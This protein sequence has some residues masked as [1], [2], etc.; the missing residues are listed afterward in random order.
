[1]VWHC[2]HSSLS[3]SKAGKW[4]H[5][6]LLLQ[7]GD[8]LIYTRS[9]AEPGEEGRQHSLLQLL[10]DRCFIHEQEQIFIRWA[11]Q[12]YGPNPRSNVKLPGW[13]HGC[14]IPDS[15]FFLEARSGRWKMEHT[16]PCLGLARKKKPTGVWGHDVQIRT[17]EH[18]QRLPPEHARAASMKFPEPT[19]G[20][21]CS[22]FPELGKIQ[23]SNSLKALLSKN[24]SQKWRKEYDKTFL[25][26][27]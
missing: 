9:P 12:S 10:Q 23:L 24:P 26:A 1:M 16:Y 5:L 14:W 17:Y 11:F 8:G 18:A 22:N 20:T 27:I 15:L 13:G 19:L 4:T 21:C 6:V 25:K 7:H 3:N 2:P